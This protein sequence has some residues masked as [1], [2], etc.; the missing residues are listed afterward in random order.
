MSDRGR[1]C[2]YAPH[3]YPVTAR[4][5]IELVG[6]AEVIQW[7]LARGLAARGFDVSIATCDYGQPYRV[8]REGVTLLRTF[9]PEAGVRMLRFFYPR[10]WKATRA[11]WRVRADVYMAQGSG[12]EAGLAY[13]LARLRRVAFVFLAAHDFDALPSVPVLPRRRH[14]WWYLR[15]LRGAETRIAQTEVQR[16]LFLENF[17]LDTTVIGNPAEIPAHAV[18]PAANRV[19]LWLATYKPSKRPEWFTELARRLP[20]HQFVMVGGLPAISGINQSWERARRAADERPNLTVHGFVERE[21]IGDFLKQAALFVH[22]S[23]AEGFPMAVLEAWSYGIPSV[24]AVDPNGAVARFGLG[25]VVT[26]IDGLVE[27]VG[28]LMN[29][30]EGRRTAGARARTYVE[31][32]HAQ[33]V[34]YDQVASLLESV[35]EKRRASSGP[36]P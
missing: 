9:S 15:A 32:H 14:R 26:T 20:E 7:S 21:R 5:E 4:G 35:I 16:R 29:D 1:L 10:L 22:T 12:I 25:E 8:E 3:L 19:V 17:G 31:D 28:R 6:G 18:N 13:D 24:T 23:P 27:A 30:A 33:N 11:L 36:S 34:I 2:F